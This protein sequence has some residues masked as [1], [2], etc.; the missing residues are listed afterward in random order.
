[1]AL[2]TDGAFLQQSGIDGR[3]VQTVR[4]RVAQCQQRIDQLSMQHGESNVASQLPEAW[5][6]T[7][8]AS[9]FALSVAATIESLV[10]AFSPEV[11]N[12]IKM[13]LGD[14]VAYLQN[15]CW[16]R[17]QFPPA[18]RPAMARPHSWHQ[19]GALGFD[20]IG[21]DA[22]ADSALLNMVVIWIPLDSCGLHAPGLELIKHSPQHLLS[23]DQLNDASVRRNYASEHFWQPQ[24]E[25]GD[26]LLMAAH[27]LH[28]TFS[29]DR[30]S[31][32]RS[33]IEIRLVAAD[34]L[35]ERV[36]LHAPCKVNL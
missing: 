4:A 14:D 2:A 24:M 6:Y 33:S 3:A 23:L 17:R 5:R 27:C 20:F 7:V 15:A 10:A 1:M 28:H 8:T 30:M 12:T 25:P 22:A 31:R 18:L 21:G 11:K 16:V 32:V 9:S 36:M 34:D 13:Q 26:V 19:D 35:T 29:T